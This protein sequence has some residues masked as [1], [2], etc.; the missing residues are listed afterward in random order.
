VEI[1]AVDKRKGDGAKVKQV[2]IIQC[3]SLF[4]VL[5]AMH[6]NG[7]GE[8]QGCLVLRTHVFVG[9]SQ[10]A[11]QHRSRFLDT[12]QALRLISFWWHALH[13]TCDAT[14][15]CFRWKLRGSFTTQVR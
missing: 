14:L 3:Y 4:T 10:I 15:T 13:L 5:A 2:S 7:T 9:R 6:L 12:A 1:T 8:L 11:S